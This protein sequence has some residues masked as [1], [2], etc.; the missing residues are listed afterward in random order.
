M[1]YLNL[2]NGVY[3]QDSTHFQLPGVFENKYPGCG[4]GA[5]TAGLKLDLI[6]NYQNGASK[7]VLRSG[8]TNDYG[9]TIK[10]IAP[11]SLWLRDMG[12]CEFDGLEYIDQQGG[13]Y[14]SRHRS[15]VTIYEGTEKDAN[16][17]EL[18]SLI[19]DLAENQTKEMNVYLGYK[20]RFPVRLIIEK[21]PNEIANQKKHKLITNKQH[22]RKTISE[23]RL[24]LCHLNMF[25][26]NIQA[27]TVPA[28]QIMQ[29]YRVRWQIELIF[30]IW[31]SHYQIHTMKKM[32]LERM[33]C[34]L[35]GRLILILMNMMIV[36]SIK[37]QYWNRYGIELS[38]YIAHKY[39]R[40]CNHLDWFK[41]MGKRQGKL[42]STI[43]KLFYLLGR[44]AI[45]SVKKKKLSPLKIS[46]T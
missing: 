7:I 9:Q 23:R 40:E 20:K 8:N 6:N 37:I 36:N 44:Y 17:I 26:T 32:K 14:I 39:L 34:H 31:K 21:L 2:L 38:D 4:G 29:L 46:L 18:T 5:S 28:T 22:K 35:Y 19:A 10:H 30:K 15:D 41:V 42:K 1:D 3:L 12:Y 45:K 43:R 11:G 24:I 33:E 16:R 27:E 25:I 13:Y